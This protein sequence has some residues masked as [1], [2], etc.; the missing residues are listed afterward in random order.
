M[1]FSGNH[2]NITGYGQPKCIPD[3]LTTIGNGAIESLA[4]PGLI[5]N[6]P[7]LKTLLTQARLYLSDNRLGV[8][9]ARII[10][11]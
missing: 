10:R 2:Y 7:P 3:R 11:R 8:L 4:R 5:N 9:A 1:A 6:R